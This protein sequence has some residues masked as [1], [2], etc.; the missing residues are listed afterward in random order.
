MKRLEVDKNLVIVRPN[1]AKSELDDI[2]YTIRLSRHLETERRLSIKKGYEP[3][4]IEQLNLPIFNHIL[5]PLLPKLIK[6]PGK[7]VIQIG[8]KPYS[9]LVYYFLVA[10]EENKKVPGEWFITLV[11]TVSSSDTQITFKRVDFSKRHMSNYYY[12][13]VCQLPELKY[14]EQEMN[15]E[16]DGN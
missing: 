16:Q 5:R 10:V 8:K 4:K 13:E 7:H 11:T 9:T 1:F 6:D 15:K 2:K 12:D 3:R 14:E